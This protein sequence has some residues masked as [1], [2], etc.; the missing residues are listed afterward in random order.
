MKARWLTACWLM[1]FLGGSTVLQAATPFNITASDVTMPH[2]G[3]AASQFV[4]TGIPVTG[5]IVLSCG[6][7]GSLALGGLPICPM[8]PPRAYSVTGGGTLQGSISF[9]PPGYAIPASEPVTGVALGGA[10]L[11]LFGFMRRRRDWMRAMFLSLAGFAAM[12][13]FSACASPGNAMPKG[14][15]PYTITAVNNPAAGNGPAYQATTI[16]KVTV[17]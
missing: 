8:T 4:I 11:C 16:V 9:Y 3:A 17:P 7:S 14:T 13:T 5:T 1:L 12:S 6:Y 10:L 15:F 2:S